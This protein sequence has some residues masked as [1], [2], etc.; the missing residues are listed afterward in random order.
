MFY[1]CGNIKAKYG[2]DTD[3]VVFF[4]LVDEIEDMDYQ[5]FKLFYR[6]PS[7]SL[8]NR[9][10]EIRADKEVMEMMQCIENAKEK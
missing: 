4:D 7:A 2:L 5:R 10:K 9:L 3:R 1:V 8:T 6:V